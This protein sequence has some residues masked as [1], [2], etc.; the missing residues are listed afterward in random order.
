GCF[1]QNDLSGCLTSLARG[2]YNKLKMLTDFHAES[3]FCKTEV[4]LDRRF[5]LNRPDSPNSAPAVGRQASSSIDPSSCAAR[6][7]RRVRRSIPGASSWSAVPALVLGTRRT[8]CA[9]VSTLR[10]RRV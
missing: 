4:S 7:D 1:H 10:L 5:R 3:T 9:W 2:V 8:Y 6:G